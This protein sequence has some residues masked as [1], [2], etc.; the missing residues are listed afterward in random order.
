MD[1]VWRYGGQITIDITYPAGT[2]ADP[3]TEICVAFVVPK[4]GSGLL[5]TM[6]EHHI[7]SVTTPVNLNAVNGAKCKNFSNIWGGQVDITVPP[8]LGATSCADEWGD[9]TFSKSGS[10]SIPY[11]PRIVVYNAGTGTIPTGTKLTLVLGAYMPTTMQYQYYWPATPF[12][13]VNGSGWQSV[14]QVPKNLS[15]LWKTPYSFRSGDANGVQISVTRPDYYVSSVVPPF[16][17]D[18]PV[19]VWA[20]GTHLV[21]SYS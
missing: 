17:T 8:I 21:G 16:A 11:I 18:L 7:L 15:G 12:N 2:A 4:I 14:M 10:A 3:N 13:I 6:T 19:T 5:T 9:V 1:L 20:D